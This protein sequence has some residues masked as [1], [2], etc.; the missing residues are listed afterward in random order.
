MKTSVDGKVLLCSVGEAWDLPMYVQQK[1]H[2]GRLVKI[3]VIICH[4]FIPRNIYF[5]V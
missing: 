1:T 2:Y 5:T 3:D 4:I